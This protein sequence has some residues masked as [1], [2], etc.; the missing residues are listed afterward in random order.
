VF[1]RECDLEISLPECPGLLVYRIWTIE[2]KIS[3]SRATIGTMMPIVYVL[4]D[5]AI[6][7][8]AALLTI[9]VCFVCANNAQYIMLDM[10]ITVNACYKVLLNLDQDHANHLDFFLYGVVSPYTQG[11]Y[12]TSPPG[13]L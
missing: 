1:P 9:L 5:A 3:S 2:R 11:N 4:I 7:Y 13:D 6:M 10:V 8:S 12:S